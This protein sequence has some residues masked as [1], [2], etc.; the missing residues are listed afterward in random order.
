MKNNNI[1]LSV[2]LPVYNY[3]KLIKQ[4]IIKLSKKIASFT[5]NFEILIVNDGSSDQTKKF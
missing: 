5:H 1:E 2:I 3:E 4:N